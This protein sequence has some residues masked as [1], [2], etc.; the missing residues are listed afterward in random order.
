MEIHG[1]EQAQ[2]LNKLTEQ[3]IL[4]AKPLHVRVD[5]RF[6]RVLPKIEVVPV[7]LR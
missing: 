2:Q 7:K 1:P 3:Y 4:D 6:V 5:S